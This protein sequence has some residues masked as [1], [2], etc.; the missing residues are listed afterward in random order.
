MD[1]GSIRC[2][3]LGSQLDRRLVATASVL[4]SSAA[5]L[6]AGASLLRV[7]RSRREFPVQRRREILVALRTTFQD[8]MPGAQDAA[9]IVLL[10]APGQYAEEVDETRGWNPSRGR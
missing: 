2:G 1:R 3:V 7:H 9:D 10:N 5:H 4:R 6:R 8:R